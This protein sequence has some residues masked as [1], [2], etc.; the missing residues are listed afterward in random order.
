M[1]RWRN[2]GTEM[3][4][5]GQSLRA[6]RADSDTFPAI[7]PTEADTLVSLSPGRFPQLP[8]CRKAKVPRG[9]K[10]PFNTRGKGG[11]HP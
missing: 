8:P 11:G 1:P 5:L 7:V 2:W 10:K 3:R 4:Q 6:N 9:G